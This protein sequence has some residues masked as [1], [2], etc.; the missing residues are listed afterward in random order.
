A[1]GVSK[2]NYS[3]HRITNEE[4][5]IHSHVLLFETSI[6]QIKIEV[7]ERP[8]FS[9]DI[10]SYKAFFKAEGDAEFD[11]FAAIFYLI[12]RYEEYLPHKKDSYGRYAY[13]N[14]VAFKSNFLHLPLIDIWLNDFKALLEDKFPDIQITTPKFQ[15]LPTYDIDI[16]WSY[17]NKGFKRNAGAI[18]KSLFT[19]RFRQLSERIR[20]LR[21]KSQDPFDAYEW[22]DELHKKYKLSPIYFFLVA[23]EQGKYDKNID[24]ESVEFQQLVKDVAS[25]YS[26][27][28]HPSWASGTQPSLLPKEKSSLEKLIDAPVEHSRQHFIRFELPATY[29][30]LITLGIYNDYSMGYGS[31]NGFRASTSRPFYWYDLKNDIP[32]H[33]LVQPF[34]FMEATSFYEQNYTAENAFHEIMAYLKIVQSVNGTMITIWH[35]SFLGSD[36]T[37]DGWKEIYEKFVAA[38]VSSR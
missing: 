37:F 15:F 14:S 18:T 6:R 30:R 8:A 4:I 12:S 24:I 16:A 21:G 3:Y 17:R 2:I 23:A 10:P 25:K 26:I 1:K 22:L 19:G 32:T 28:L 36:P 5:W 29:R 27:G 11:V 38:A 33:L 9:P 13:D 35:N 34:C 20:V 7:F 31:I